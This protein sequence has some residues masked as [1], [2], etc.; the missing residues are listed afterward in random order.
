M[1]SSVSFQL[2]GVQAIIQSS[3][4]IV[5]AVLLGLCSR[6]R[7]QLFPGPQP[8]C[9]PTAHG[10]DRTEPPRSLASVMKRFSFP[11]DKRGGVCR[12]L[13]LA[14]PL[15]AERVQ[16]FI[17]VGIHCRSCTVPSLWYWTD[18]C[19]VHVNTVEFHHIIFGRFAMFTGTRNI[20]H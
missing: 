14:L 15:L 18:C 19:G 17:Q 7:W 9:K 16:T 4:L 12:V 11:T 20:I 1:E 8:L 13:A 2:R 5:F 6:L 10:H 3:T